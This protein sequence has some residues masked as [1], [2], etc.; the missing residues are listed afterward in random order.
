MI[1]VNASASVN[2]A[3]ALSICQGSLSLGQSGVSLKSII[4][5]GDQDVSVVDLIGSDAAIAS[6][7]CQAVSGS[8]IW[9]LGDFYDL[10][11]EVSDYSLRLYETELTAEDFDLSARL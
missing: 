3:S 1:S 9:T 10:S 8:E 4:N 5:F 11:A 6:N 7:D 2:P